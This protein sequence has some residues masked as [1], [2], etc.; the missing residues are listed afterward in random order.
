MAAVALCD[1]VKTILC[2]QRASAPNRVGLGAPC[3]ETSR[4]LNIDFPA[5][6]A[7]H[8]HGQGSRAFLRTLIFPK[9]FLPIPFSTLVPLVI[10]GRLFIAVIFVMVVVLFFVSCPT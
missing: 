7:R 5:L 4:P 6:S 3:G 1:G 2:S 10:N 8:Q 9:P